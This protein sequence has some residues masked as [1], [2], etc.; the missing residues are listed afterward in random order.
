MADTNIKVTQYIKGTGGESSTLTA[1]QVIAEVQ[2]IL[3]T[4]GF[5]LFQMFARP[6]ERNGGTFTYKT[7]ERLIPQAYVRTTNGA[8]GEGA[9]VPQ[10]DIQANIRDVVY[11]EIEDTEFATQVLADAEKTRVAN[12]IVQSMMAQLDAEAFITMKGAV[13]SKADQ[14][15]V[16]DFTKSGATQDSLANSRIALGDVI[17]ENESIID[18]KT[19]GVPSIRQLAI[20]SPLAYWRYV[21]SFDTNVKEQSDEIKVGNLSLKFINGS[22]VI[23]HPLIG[24]NFAA[25]TLHKT[26]SYGLNTV[27]DGTKARNLE[28]FILT[29][30]AMAMPFTLKQMRTRINR[31]GNEEI[32]S[33]YVYGKG[34]IR[35]GLIKAVV[36]NT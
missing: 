32:I 13:D 35:P 14:V 23:K 25:G 16:V 4:D 27:N 20:L 29:D 31:F 30:I 22:A 5:G 33:R 7:P 8:L 9:V 12:S 17:A 6:S 18:A 3:Q 11:F 1:D 34:V 15:K 24:G 19:L 2:E 28:G 36:Q 21:N 26:K 10:V